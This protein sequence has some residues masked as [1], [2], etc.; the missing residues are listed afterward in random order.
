MTS[1]DVSGEPL[2]I[3]GFA[4]PKGGG[5]RASALGFIG[6]RGGIFPQHEWQNSKAGTPNEIDEANNFHD[7][8]MEVSNKSQTHS[9][10]REPLDLTWKMRLEPSAASNPQ[11]RH[12]TTSLSPK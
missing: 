10:A 6:E 11:S 2:I 7:T 3:K 12:S 9:E 5:V 8:E 4:R 1:Y